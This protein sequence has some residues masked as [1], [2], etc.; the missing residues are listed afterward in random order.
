VDGIGPRL[1]QRILRECFRGKLRD[2]RYVERVSG[3]GPARRAAIM[4]WV[5]ARER[6]FPRL[7]KQPFPR[8]EKVQEKYRT[9]MRPLERRLNQARSDLE[10]KEAVREPL[11][12]AVDKL[13]SVRVSHFR[14]AL[15]HGSSGEPVPNWYLEGLYPGWESPPDWFNTV[16]SEYGG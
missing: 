1:R 5:R 11:K 8:K 13:R 9:K 16:L 12:A 10:E 2:L 14:K 3:V 7:I 15:R 6:E 4:A